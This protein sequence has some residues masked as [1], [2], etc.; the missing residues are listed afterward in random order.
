MLC[1]IL[2]QFF[3][4]FFSFCVL[5]EIELIKSFLVKVAEHIFGSL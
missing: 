3:A 4:I 2:K 1:N 5:M